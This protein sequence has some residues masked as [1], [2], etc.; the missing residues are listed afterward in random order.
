VRTVTE[1][2]PP[3]QT[4]E[5]GCPVFARRAG[6]HS[7]AVPTDENFSLTATRQLGHGRRLHGDGDARSATAARPP[8]V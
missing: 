7:Q 1:H 8:A 3:P 5:G 6:R 2:L 4:A